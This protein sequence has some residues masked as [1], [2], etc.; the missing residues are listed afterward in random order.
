MRPPE[1][2]VFSFH[3]G[4]GCLASEDGVCDGEQ[5]SG[6]SDGDDLSRLAFGAQ[7][8]DEPGA[9]AS[10]SERAERGHV[11]RAAQLPAAFTRL[12]GTAPLPAFAGAG[13]EPGEGGGLAAVAGTKL[14]H[15]AQKRNGG[16]AAEAGDGLQQG[17]LLAERRMARRKTSSPASSRAMPPASGGARS[18]A[19]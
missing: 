8:F 6:D 18:M 19:A 7:S 13:R 9:E 1:A 2:T 16:D 14:G 3:G 4:E 17:D 10:V 11:E 12:A 5:L 15:V